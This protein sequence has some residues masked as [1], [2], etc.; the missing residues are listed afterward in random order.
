[1]TSRNRN[2][3]VVTLPICATILLAGAWFASAGNLNPPAG[4][5]APT[6]K[7]LTEIEPRTAVNAVNT[8][9]SAT[10]L[11][12]ITQPGS[13]YLTGNI[14]GVAT[15]DGVEIDASGVTLDLNGFALV[16]VAG[17]RDGV[18]TTVP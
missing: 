2:F 14:Q 15:M 10:S 8:P 4:P 5:V 7:T 11:F 16:G 13:Y 3:A 12:T 18:T 6:G 17:S 9:P 1:M